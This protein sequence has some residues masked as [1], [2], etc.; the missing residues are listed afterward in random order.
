MKLTQVWLVAV[1]FFFSKHNHYM[2]ETCYIH[3]SPVWPNIMVTPT[4]RGM[5]TAAASAA[6]AAP[7]F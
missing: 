6:M 2:F 3:K 4:Y 1:T 5:G 7:L